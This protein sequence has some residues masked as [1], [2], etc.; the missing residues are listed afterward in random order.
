MQR[1]I[2]SAF[3]NISLAQNNVVDACAAVLA[4][5]TVSNP[6]VAVEQR[7]LIKFMVKEKVKAAEILMRLQAQYGG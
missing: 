1:A 6:S 3:L 4:I 7:C 2:T 5:M